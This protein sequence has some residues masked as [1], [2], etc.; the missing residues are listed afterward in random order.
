MFW[1]VDKHFPKF[2]HGHYFLV[3]AGSLWSDERGKFIRRTYDRRRMFLDWGGFRYLSQ[4]KGLPFGIDEF[5]DLVKYYDPLLFAPMDIPCEPHLTIPG[6]RSIGDRIEATLDHLRYFSRVDRG[7][8]I[9]VIQGYTIEQRLSC[10]E[11]IFS[12]GLD[13]PLMC[14][15]SLCTLNSAKE[16][17][18]IVTAITQAAGD[19]YQFHLFGVTLKFVLEY[20]L[21]FCGV[22]SFD[23]SAWQ[24]YA[25]YSQ[26][27]TR[28][29][30]YRAKM[31]K[32]VYI[33]SYS[34]L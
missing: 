7:A 34:T 14:I 30:A 27:Q 26:L 23:T 25:K 10:L 12:L 24:Y 22:F 18:E 11:R 15:G 9:P 21:S 2:L 31:P 20:D 6:F 28:F 19:A 4:G 13:K 32:S 8:M 29:M 1:G 33:S 16:V 17:Y 3:S 5:R